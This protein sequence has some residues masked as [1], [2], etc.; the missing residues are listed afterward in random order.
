MKNSE[1]SV[2]FRCFRMLGNNWVVPVSALGLSVLGTV[3]LYG[4]ML[5]SVGASATVCCWLEVLSKAV[6]VVMI[7]AFLFVPLW[8]TALTVV[9][10]CRRQFRVACA[11]LWAT[12]CEV[13][14]IACM[15]L[16]SMFIHDSDYDSFADRHK[17]TEAYS[18]EYNGNSRSR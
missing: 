4:L 13:G 17:R 8:L 16:G 5:Q 11:W 12:L 7:A 6:C 2:R 9:R 14:M 10:L 1:K 3:A 18:P 15:L